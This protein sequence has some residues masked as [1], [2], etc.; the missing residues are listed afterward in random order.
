MLIGYNTNVPYKGKQYHVQTEDSGIASPFV[1][2]LLYCQGAILRSVKTGYADIVGH[3]DFEAELRKLMKHQHRE[4]IR[5]LIT[6]KCEAVK[7][8]SDEKNAQPAG[9]HEVTGNSDDDKKT[10]SL[11]DILLEHISKKVKP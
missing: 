4:M 2:T 5:E 11:D 9:G 3:P 10:R 7:G 8:D 1:V 6:G